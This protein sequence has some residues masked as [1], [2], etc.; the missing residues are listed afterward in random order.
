VD[1]AK[2]HAARSQG[3]WA[4]I[5]GETNGQPISEN[6]LIHTRLDFKGDHVK[7]DG[8]GQSGGGEGTFELDTSASPRRIKITRSEG[9]NR[10]AVMDGIYDL[11]GDHL[12]ICMGE[13]EDKVTEFK[14]RPGTHI[15]LAEFVRMVAPPGAAA[16][17]SSSALPAPP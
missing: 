14:S 1:F 13:P 16:A 5:R 10:F 17:S 11:D 7:A 12:R 9:P 2:Y 3:T 8:P 4:A 15:L 6:D